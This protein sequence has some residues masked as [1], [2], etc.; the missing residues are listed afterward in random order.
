M[1]YDNGMRFYWSAETH[2]ISHADA[3]HVIEHARTIIVL[4]EEPLKLLYIGF[5]TIGRPCEVIVD[6]PP[7]ENGEPACIHA[8]TLTP[9][10][11]KYL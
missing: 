10:W 9:A 1:G 6:H 5:D 3:V 7:W 11:Y 4:R 2:G 8:D